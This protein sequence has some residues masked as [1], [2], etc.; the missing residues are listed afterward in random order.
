MDHCFQPMAV[1]V[2]KVAE[3]VTLPGVAVVEPQALA[4]VAGA[5]EVRLR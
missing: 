5:L 4:L 2:A 3:T 1:A